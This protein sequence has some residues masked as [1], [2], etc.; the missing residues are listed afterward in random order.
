MCLPDVHPLLV[1]RK[2]IT[3]AR[4]HLW[5]PLC[6]VIALWCWAVPCALS[7][8]EG[9]GLPCRGWRF[10]LIHIPGTFPVSGCLLWRLA[11]AFIQGV[12]CL[13]WEEQG[14]LLSQRAAGG[15]RMS[16]NP[17][18]LGHVRHSAAQLSQCTG[19]IYSTA[20]SRLHS[21]IK[22]EILPQCHIPKSSCA[23]WGWGLPEP[24]PNPKAGHSVTAELYWA[25]GLCLCRH[26]WAVTSL[27]APTLGCDIP[28]C[29]RWQS[30][31][32]SWRAPWV[33]TFFRFCLLT[34]NVLLTEVNKLWEFQRGY[35]T[36]F[37]T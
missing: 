13:V 7:V 18:S 35:C 4:S 31:P 34:A 24:P 19:V 22:S 26:C 27:A 2:P 9:Q 23:A 10:V 1:N 12:L 14:V 36:I 29:S 32:Q 3:E 17:D 20:I 37:L 6:A 5:D 21:H 25:F 30:L 16:V 15:C 28:G 11:H 33:G 8:G